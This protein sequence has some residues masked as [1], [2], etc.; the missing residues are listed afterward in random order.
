MAERPPS[1][2]AMTYG[3]EGGEGH[4]AAMTDGSWP[5]R[6]RMLLLSPRRLQARTTVGVNGLVAVAGL[7]DK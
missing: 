7:V 6:L 4:H 1:A 3:P 5:C 2:A